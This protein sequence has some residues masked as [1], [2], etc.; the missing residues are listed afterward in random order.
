[1][2]NLLIVY[3]NYIYYLYKLP[4]AEGKLVSICLRL[5]VGIFYTINKFCYLFFFSFKIT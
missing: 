4:S 3:N 1:M 5:R 2:N